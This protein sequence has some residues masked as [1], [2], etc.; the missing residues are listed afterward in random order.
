MD[1]AHQTP[2]VRER[3]SAGDTPAIELRSVSKR[4][5]TPNGGTY[6]ALRDLDLAVERGQLP[7]SLDD[8]S[9]IVDQLIGI[10]Q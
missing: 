8:P 9:L 4:F 10:P 3:R 2:S 5:R 6:T 7:H 1:E